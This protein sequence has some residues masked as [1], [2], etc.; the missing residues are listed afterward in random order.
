ME[1]VFTTITEGTG[2]VLGRAPAPWAAGVEPTQAE[3]LGY[4][5]TTDVN[6]SVLAALRQTGSRERGARIAGLFLAD[7]FLQVED[8]ARQLRRLDVASIANLPTVQLIDGEAGRALERTRHGRSN[9][10]ER[11]RAF[12]A[13]GFAI[14]AVAFDR[15]MLDACLT[16]AP[17]AVILHP[18]FA[19]VR[20]EARRKSL[21]GVRAM[22]KLLAGPGMPTRLLYH[23]QGMPEEEIAAIAG[24]ADG[25]VRL[26]PC[27]L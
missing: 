22:L 3:L 4:A 26:Q 13:L 18:G 19:A 27:S 5:P 25:M 17:D 9:E 8:I 2:G 16:L 21:A 7:P 20:P 12:K 23:P 11:L 24:L 15:D 1:W 14:F 10:F 6:G